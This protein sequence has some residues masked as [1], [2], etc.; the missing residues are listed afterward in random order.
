M[1]LD[2][3]LAEHLAQEAFG[4]AIAALG[5][6]R[7]DSAPRTS[8]LELARNG[9]L[10]RL[11]SARRS[12]FDTHV[13][14]DVDAHV[15]DAPPAID[16]LVRR[17]DA[18]RAL[19]SLAETERAI[20]VLHFGHG[21]GYGELADAFGMKEG[22]VRMRVSRAVGR[23]RDALEGE[24]VAGAAAPAAAPAARKSA[25]GLLDGL[26]RWVRGEPQ[27]PA[28]EERAA[29]P[30]APLHEDATLDADRRAEEEPP[31]RSAPMPPPAAAPSRIPAPAYAG[32][33]RHPLHET[34]PAPL[35]GRLRALLDAMR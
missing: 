17:E 12:P 20:V 16:L 10:E 6:F 21:V 26:G 24:Q 19:S 4:R 9:C 34:A 2:D 32:P 31:R 18:Q 5:S 27:A 13:E 23:M 8:V 14:H 22:A 28:R 15:G 35:L 29:R 1:V 11:A 30:R 33:P 25:G 3:T 7:S